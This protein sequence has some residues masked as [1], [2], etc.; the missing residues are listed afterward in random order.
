MNLEHKVLNVDCGE[1]AL[2]L[3]ALPLVCVGWTRQDGSYGVRTFL[4][5]DCALEST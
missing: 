2:A 1:L 4:H 3:V 5:A